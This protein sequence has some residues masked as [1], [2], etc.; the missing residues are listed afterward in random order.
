MKLVDKMA[1]YCHESWYVWMN[2]LFSHSTKNT[3]GSVTI[4][5]EFV[6]RWKRQMKTPYN[7]LS[8]EEQE[9][10]K[11]EARK[12]LTVCKMWFEDEMEI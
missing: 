10:D 1:K 2:Y 4:P 5:K 11:I 8:K 3:D 9:S 6:D 7:K 12:I